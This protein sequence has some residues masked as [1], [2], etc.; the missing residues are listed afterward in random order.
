[1]AGRGADFP[2]RLALP[3]EEPGVIPGGP[4]AA[5]PRGS[6][7]IF[8]TFPLT[9]TPILWPDDITQ[10]RVNSEDGKS[11]Y[12]KP[13]RRTGQARL[14]IRRPEHGAVQDLR[15]AGGPASR[16]VRLESRRHPARGV[17]AEHRALPGLTTRL[18]VT[19]G[20]LREAFPFPQGFPQHR[21]VASR[22]GRP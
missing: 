3:L 21:L 8:D 12:Q 13:K 9:H 16:A 22:G 2:L 7:G 1:M 5:R 10:N 6:K 11:F 18:A 14:Q 19:R 20:L 4:L 17:A 15:R